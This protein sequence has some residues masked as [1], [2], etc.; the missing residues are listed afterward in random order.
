MGGRDFDVVY[1]H[2]ML[3][4]L[5]R[6]VAAL[7]EM[8]RVLRSGGLVGVRDS[9]YG[10]CTWSPPDERITQ[11]LRV[12]HAVARANGA[13]ADAGRHLHGWLQQAGF[14][15]LRM[16]GTTWTFPGYD[17][18]ATWANA[19]ADRTTASNLAT[20][21]LEYGIASARSSRRS[22]T[23]SARGAAIPRRSSASDTSRPSAG[24]RDLVGCAVLRD[25]GIGGPAV[26]TPRGATR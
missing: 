18:V 12:Y 23:A 13:D 6:P 10:T 4:H 11:W 7:A 19:W 8:Q 22:P 25:G 16:S 2:Q 15:E 9:D 20:K 24:S 1:A 14:V 17:A 26:L 3:Q 21:A 5:S